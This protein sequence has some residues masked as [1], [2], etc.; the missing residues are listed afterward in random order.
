MSEK[1][2]KTNNEGD[3]SEPASQTDIEVNRQ[4]EKETEMQFQS[5]FVREIYEKYLRKMCRIIF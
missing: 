1:L 2:K 3:V 4:T 5:R